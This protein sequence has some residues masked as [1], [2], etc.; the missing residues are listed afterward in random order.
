MLLT[1]AVVENL[2]P[3]KMEITFKDLRIKPHT[4]SLGRVISLKGPEAIS[5]LNS[6]VTSN[7]LDLKI[8]NFHHSAVLTLSGGIVASFIACKESENCTHI[9]IPEGVYE[10]AIQRLQK[11]HI[12][13]DL[14]FEPSTL[15]AY[16]LVNRDEKANSFEGSY[17]FEGN[18]IV[19]CE[20]VLPVDREEVFTKYS[21]LTGTPRWGI[22]NF[23]NEIINNTRL[24]DL[25]VNYKKGCY[26]GQETVAKIDSRRGAAFKP[27]LLTCEESIDI[28]LGKLLVE[29]KK[30]GEVRSFFTEESKTY[31]WATLN[32]EKRIDKKVYE[33]EIGGKSVNLQVNYLPYLELGPR[34]SSREFYDC[35]VELF[36]HNR[37]DDALDYFEQSIGLDP[38]YEDAYESLGVLLGRLGRYD[39]AIAMMEK[40]K[41][42]NPKCLMAYTNL[43]LYHM[44]VG[45]IEKAEKYKADATLLNFEVLGSNAKKKKE[46]EA[47]E[48]KKR[49]ESERREHMFLQVLEIDPLD[50]MANNGLGELCFERHEFEIAKDYF[51]KAIEGDKK[52]SVAYL[53]LGKA[54]VKLNEN[55]QAR[56]IL[57]E[58]IRVASKN[59]D[60]M[61]ANEMQSMLNNLGS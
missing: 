34:E 7:I 17:F 9:V 35:A 32:R 36:K 49:A 29:G 47:F 21:L 44:K 53:G 12:S 31:I 16:L 30:V 40:L 48:A 4:F 41:A 14:E 60:L 10:E 11:F 24:D 19:L 59:G 23:P 56:T 22:E 15:N 42:I 18:K 3:F 28:S 26:P 2:S 58:G 54:L 5:Y 45:E 57:S 25:A 52:Y 61:P 43:S 50:S 38:N 46:M 33:F 13:E 27:V 51:K 6:Q 8:G 39:K 55:E 37:D 1:P 20:D